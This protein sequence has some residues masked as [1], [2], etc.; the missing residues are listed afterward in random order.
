M[1]RIV[2]YGAQSMAARSPSLT[3]LLYLIPILGA[4]LALLELQGTIFPRLFSRPPSAE[5]VPAQ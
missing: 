2:G 5:P 3:F 4:G 1:L